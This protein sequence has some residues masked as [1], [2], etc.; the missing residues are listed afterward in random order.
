MLQMPDGQ[1]HVEDS[2]AERTPTTTTYQE[3]EHVQLDL[4]SATRLFKVCLVLH[5]PWIG[6]HQHRDRIPRRLQM[7]S[8]EG[9]S[10]WLLQASP[11]SSSRCLPQI[12]YRRRDLP[13]QRGGAQSIRKLYSGTNN[14][15]PR[16]SSRVII[17]IIP[18]H[19]FRLT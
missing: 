5:K 8:D 16:K 17:P 2:S 14:P 3:F 18:A 4:S 1:R 9:L 19:I 6:S 12:K 13:S 7:R 15:M 10:C 11:Q